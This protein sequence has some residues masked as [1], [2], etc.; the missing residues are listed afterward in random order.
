MPSNVKRTQLMKSFDMKK[1]DFETILD[2]LGIKKTGGELEVEELEI[3]LETVT[4]RNQIGNLADYLSGKATLV[5]EGKEA[6]KTE[7]PKTEAPKTEAPKTEAAKTE[8][9]KTEAAKTETSKTEAA[10]TETPKAEASKVDTAE[11]ETPKKET[12]HKAETSKMGEHK[13]EKK[14]P[15]TES[16]PK[17]QAKPE[18][19]KP[20]EKKPEKKPQKQT[21]KTIEMKPTNVGAG[22]GETVVVK[23]KSRVVD[24]R[25][26]YDGDLSK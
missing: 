13:D 22:T 15:V 6:P 10:K 18:A 16:Q 26:N 4:L 3:F 12:S 14:L 25:G 8:T 9:P 20:A 5:V 11:T 7:T 23:S 24:T 2:E 21:L 17:P 1:K 19:P